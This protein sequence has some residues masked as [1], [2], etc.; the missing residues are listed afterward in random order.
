MYSFKSIL[1]N[2]YNSLGLNLNKRE[3]NS[4]SIS[5]TTKRYKSKSYLT[6]PG[7]N[8]IQNYRGETIW[9]YDTVQILRYMIPLIPQHL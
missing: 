1:Y 5:A 3:Q 6:D 7:G 4:C 8:L 9:L 2:L